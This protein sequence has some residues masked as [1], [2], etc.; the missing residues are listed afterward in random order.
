MQSKSQVQITTGFDHGENWEPFIESLDVKRIRQTIANFPIYET[1]E[2]PQCNEIERAVID[3]TKAISTTRNTGDVKTNDNHCEAL[4]DELAYSDDERYSPSFIMPLLLGV[5]E[6][7]ARRASIEETENK[8]TNEV[9]DMDVD[10]DNEYPPSGEEGVDK[11][12]DHVN[13]YRESF[14]K[15]VYRLSQKGAISLSLACLSSRCQDIRRM[16]VS[17]LYFF[18]QAIKMDESQS[19]GQWRERPQIEMILNSV[20]RGL[21]VAKVKSMQHDEEGDSSDVALATVPM[22][23][24]VSA[25]FLARSIFIISKPGDSMFS[26][27]NKYFLRIEDYHGAFNDCF[28]LPAFIIL[29]SSANDDNSQ[30]RRERLWAL[31]LLKDGIIDEY[32]YKVVSRRH[33]PSLL[34]SSFDGFCSR[35]SSG[36][37]KGKYSGIYDTE[38]SMVLEVVE[39]CLIHGGYTAY[40]HFVNVIG[41]FPWIQAMFESHS[42]TNCLNESFYTMILHALQGTERYQIISNDM[43]RKESLPFD[44]MNIL[45]CVLGAYETEEECDSIKDSLR[46]STLLNTVCDI[47][48]KIHQLHK[49]NDA[50]QDLYRIFQIHCNGVPISTAS[51]IAK[52]TQQFVSLHFNLIEALCYFPIAMDM[53]STED[54]F[55]LVAF[56]KSALNV[57]L[58]RGT[59][60]TLP[61]DARTETYSCIMKRINFFVFNINFAPCSFLNDVEVGEMLLSCRRQ[62]LHAGLYDLWLETITGILP[63]SKT[64]IDSSVFSDVKKKQKFEAI[65]DLIENEKANNNI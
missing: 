32:S 8:Q 40:N 54:T 58:N 62:M 29:F 64:D 1:A 55:H 33:V 15:I 48:R 41:I 30:A 18:I 51:R 57:L 9:E 14:A 56:T 16:A 4:V 28:S 12:D 35:K 37:R 31:Q 59:D 44:A 7:F 13:V 63:K 47:V 38:C 21:V 3:G 61:N 10:D 26:A 25:I 46:P 34:L 11:Y 39:Q 20:Q 17:T 50:S 45:N 5:L 52:T 60:I 36:E 23:P 2:P 6:S 42:K 49:N 27:I 43:T 22:L 24:S 19:I 65:V 53:K